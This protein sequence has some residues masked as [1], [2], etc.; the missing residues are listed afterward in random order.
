MQAL[1]QHH[2]LAGL[3]QGHAVMPEPHVIPPRAAAGMLA[4]ILLLAGAYIW[5]VNSPKMELSRAARSAG[6]TASM[7]TYVPSSYAV[8]TSVDAAPGAVTMQFHSP[9]ID[10]PLKIVQRPTTWDSRSL[11][12]NFVSSQTQNYAKIDGQGLTIYVWNNGQASWINHGIWYTIEGASKLSQEQ[13]LKIAYG[14]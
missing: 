7:P 14:L 8:R 9:S 5:S 10:K 2:R 13:I 3:A 11:L 4:A 12:A 1:T 6:F